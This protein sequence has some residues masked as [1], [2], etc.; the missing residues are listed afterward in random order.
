MLAM[1]QCSFIVFHP[2]HYMHVM[3]MRYYANLICTFSYWIYI[4]IT[5]FTSYVL[6]HWIYNLYKL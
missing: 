2:Q 1:N 5:T 4:I 3:C 6:W